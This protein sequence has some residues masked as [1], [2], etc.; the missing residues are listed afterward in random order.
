MDPHRLARPA[1]AGV[2]DRDPLQRLAVH[3][4]RTQRV[5]AHSRVLRDLGQ[6]GRQVPGGVREGAGNPDRGRVEA[7]RDHH[8]A[9]V[10]YRNHA[11]RH[12]RDF[13]FFEV[14]PT[15]AIVGIDRHKVIRKAQSGEL[16]AKALAHR[17]LVGP[18]VPPGPKAVG[19]AGVVVVVAQG[20]LPG[21]AVAI[22]LLHRADAAGLEIGGEANLV[23]AGAAR[24]K[25]QDH[26]Q[27]PEAGP[28]SPEPTCW[29]VIRFHKAIDSGRPIGLRMKTVSLS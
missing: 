23:L 15:G 3:R 29:Q 28:G 25:K 18:Q 10:R 14:L 13:A 11:A 8:T 16:H 24:G 17:H 27:D 9:A 19:Q 12:Q 22:E 26:E 2:G 7:L 20:Q 1:G 6:E 21:K 4:G 5:D